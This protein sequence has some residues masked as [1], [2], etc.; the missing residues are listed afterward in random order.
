MK[1]F[2]GGYDPKREELIKQLESEE[3]PDSPYR[4][5]FALGRETA[6]CFDVFVDYR[7]F[8]M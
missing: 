1:A 2:G 4:E 7:T 6:Q 5:T 3:V 8:S